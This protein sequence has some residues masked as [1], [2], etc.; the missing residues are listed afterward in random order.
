MGGKHWTLSS[1]DLLQGCLHFNRR[2]KDSAC[3]DEGGLGG[4]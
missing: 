1:M 4:N 2:K 3:L